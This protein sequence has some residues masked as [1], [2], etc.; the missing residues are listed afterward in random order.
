MR[1]ASGPPGAA[2]V[3]RREVASDT[4]V[5]KV[6]GDSTVL[7]SNSPRARVK[8]FRDPVD[9]RAFHHPGLQAASGAAKVAAKTHGSTRAEAAGRVIAQGDWHRVTSDVQGVS[10]AARRPLGKV[11]VD[12]KIDVASLDVPRLRAI[13]RKY[14]AFPPSYRLLVWRHLL[15]LPGNRLAFKALQEQRAHPAFAALHRTLALDDHGAHNGRCGHQNGRMQRLL[16]CLAHW[17]PALAELPELP[18][19]LQP[20]LVLFGGD[21]LG[22]FEACATLLANWTARFFECHPHPPVAVLAPCEEQR[23]V[24]PASAAQP[25]DWPRLA[26]APD[27]LRHDLALRGACGEPAGR[28]L[29]ELVF[30]IGAGEC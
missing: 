19:V 28:R 21:Q 18:A 4:A 20:W 26:E 11:A 23:P 5:L 3:S 1:T 15:Q 24:W 9:P 14:G 10:M 13:L 16:S 29:S 8:S 30:H 25:A 2:P 7:V 27:S 17:C 6:A 12:A 22:A